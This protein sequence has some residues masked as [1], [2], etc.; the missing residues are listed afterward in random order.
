MLKR[1]QA[2][3][4]SGL[5]EFCCDSVNTVSVEAAVITEK[6]WVGVDEIKEEGWG[7]LALR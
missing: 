4:R 5:T 3:G 7:G 2:K 6:K 1:R